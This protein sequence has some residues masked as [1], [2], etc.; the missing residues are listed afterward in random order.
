MIGEGLAVYGNGSINRA[1]AEDTG[2]TISNAPKM[3]AAAGL[4]YTQDSWASS[5][6]Y[7][8]TG[9]N[10]QQ[11]FDPAKPASYEFYKLA[12]Y[13]NADLGASYT[14]RYLAEGFKALKL[15]LNIFNLFDR[16]KVT[17]ISPGK[18]LAGDQYTYQAPRSYQVSLRAD[19]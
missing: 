1:T 15:Q 14:F 17:S 6:I 8:R 5:F 18:T 19:F 2:K 12:A 16:H 11:D 10:Y 7:K 13:N 3:T 4:I 9:E